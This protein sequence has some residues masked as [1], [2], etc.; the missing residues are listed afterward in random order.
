M[1]GARVR[2]LLLSLSVVLCSGAGMAA[3]A[4]DAPRPESS[5]VLHLASLEWL[6][7]TGS[8][9]DGDGLDSTIA[10]VA[11]KQFASTVRVDYFPWKRAMQMGV[12]DP[13]FSGYFP[14]YYTEERART[15]YFS[16]PMGRSTV[17]LAYLR[18]EPLQWEHLSDLEGVRLGVVAGFSNGKE[19]D[20]LAALGKLQL[21][22]SP[23]DGINL[24]KLL[25]GRIRAAVIDKLVLRYLLLVD[26]SLQAGRD[27]IV[28]H[29]NV[30]ADL[31]L[32]I[33]FHRNADGLR[34]QKNFDEAL[35][36][37]DI[38][39]IENGYF[40]DLEA[41]IRTGTAGAK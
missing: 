37:M 13:A 5:N 12:E 24:R 20:A 26:P 36:H 30:L 32:H 18:S 38:A 14:A 4:G 25:A 9:L 39:K 11:A 28:F 23:T 41:K 3:W 1:S 7:Y 8:G 16:A 29:P 19:F 34:M 10:A 2:N 31:T 22:A 40:Q 35:S 33:C 15:C 17:G 27:Q 6:P 21:D